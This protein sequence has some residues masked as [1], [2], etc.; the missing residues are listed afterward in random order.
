MKQFLSTVL[1]QKAKP[2][3]N[4]SFR[5]LN[6]IAS[7][8]Y[9]TNV[10]GLARSVLALGLLLT[11][12]F[13]SKEILFT[14]SVFDSLPQETLVARLNLFGLFGYNNL[15]YAYLT[16][17]I[18][19][20]LVI[21]GVYPRITGILHWWVSYSFFTS[22]IILDGGDQLTSVL[23]IYL[24]PLTLMDDRKNHWKGISNTN[25][26]QNFFCFL[27]FL[28]C[29]IQMAIVYLLAAVEK[30]LKVDEWANGSAIYY[31]LNHNMFGAPMWTMDFFNLMFDYPLVLFCL[32]WG[33]IIFELLLFMAFFMK[34]R[35]KN[36]FLIYGIVFHLSILFVHGLV[37]FFF[38]MSA[39]LILYLARKN[40]QL[41]LRS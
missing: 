8:Q 7:K 32:N 18:I 13:N 29:Q 6:R 36:K 25:Y 15:E 30:P 16:A 22:G 21:S 9:L 4:Y 35:L 12:I 41:N 19:L 17:S 33:V 5:V 34:Q 27:I 40:S 14:A 31:W 24:L 28:F 39:G 20:L 26:Y 10:Y 2:D 11:L 3:F 37:S 38:A 1:I 23:S